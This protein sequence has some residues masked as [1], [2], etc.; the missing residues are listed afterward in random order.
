MKKHRITE[1]E[2]NRAKRQF[3]QNHGSLIPEGSEAWNQA[4]QLTIKLQ[5]QH[6]NWSAKQILE[7][8]GTKMSD[9]VI[10]MQ[11]QVA[12]QKISEQ[13]RSY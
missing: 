10:A 6:P 13:R 4:D 9:E 7:A 8:A 5:K 1:G 3:T 12:V 11:R 2:L